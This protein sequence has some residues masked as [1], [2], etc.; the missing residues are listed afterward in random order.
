MIEV[1]VE[2]VVERN[3]PL[4]FDFLSNFENNPRWQSGMQECRFTSP[5]P[6]RVGSTYVQ[7]ARFLGRTIES[8]FEVIALEP[9]RMVKAT[10]RSATYPITITR[11]VQPDERGARVSAIIEGDASGIFNLAQPLLK[12]MVQRSVESDYAR[13]KALLE[14]Q[15]DP[16]D[17]GLGQRDQGPGDPE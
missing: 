5:G 3:S 12:R 16:A 14:S 2:I 8:N 1:Q 17:T 11:R 9:G 13:L 15:A 6:L 4:V 10:S 7:T